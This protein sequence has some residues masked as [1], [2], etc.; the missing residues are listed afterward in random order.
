MTTSTTAKSGFTLRSVLPMLIFD[1]LWRAF[2]AAAG[3]DS[4]GATEIVT[5]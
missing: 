2:A 5:S 1:G 3:R 4:R